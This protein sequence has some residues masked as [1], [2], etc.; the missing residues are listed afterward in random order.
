MVNNSGTFLGQALFTFIWNSN[1]FLLINAAS[2]QDWVVVSLL[3]QIFAD[4]HKKTIR[5][6]DV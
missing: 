4:G 5:I 1:D 6:F 2:Q 3:F